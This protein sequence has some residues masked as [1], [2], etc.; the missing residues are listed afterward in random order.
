VVDERAT[1]AQLSDDEHAAVRGRREALHAAI[2]QL[3]QELAALGGATPP[4]RDRLV[5]ALEALHATLEEHVRGAD[6]PA[7]LLQQVVEVAPWLGPRVRRL[8]DDH[9]ALR[10]HAA[11]LVDRARRG[12]DPADVVADAHELAAHVG[13]HRHRAAAVILDAYNLDLAASD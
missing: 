3:E 8:Q 10:D 1:P 12:T 4:D 5:R 9:R 2:G 11:E 7:G 6:A 13:A